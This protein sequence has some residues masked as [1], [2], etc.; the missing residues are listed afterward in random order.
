MRRHDT[1]RFNQAVEVS[2]VPLPLCD[3]FGE[4]RRSDV[5]TFNF[6]PVFSCLIDCTT[7]RLGIAQR[8]FDREQSPIFI[9]EDQK[10]LDSLTA[11]ILFRLPLDCRRGWVLE[12]QPVWRAARPVGSQRGL[13]RN[14]SSNFEMAVSQWADEP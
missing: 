12:L 11:P 5:T 10:C 4:R 8:T 9:D 6:A 14:M 2:V 1:S 7:P 3:S 13:S